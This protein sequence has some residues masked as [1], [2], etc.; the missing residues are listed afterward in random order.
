MDM[1]MKTQ[2]I[3]IKV[4]RNLPDLTQLLNELKSNLNITHNIFSRI[5]KIVK[6]I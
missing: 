2:E 1:A 5:T 3:W 4:S 6:M